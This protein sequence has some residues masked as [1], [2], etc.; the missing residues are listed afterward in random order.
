MRF[1]AH[2][3]LLLFYFCLKISTGPAA[4]PSGRSSPPLLAG[5]GWGPPCALASYRRWGPIYIAVHTQRMELWVDFSE[6]LRLLMWWE[7]QQILFA[8]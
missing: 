8:G 5:G 2:L 4:E 7:S 3:K 6:V 1:L